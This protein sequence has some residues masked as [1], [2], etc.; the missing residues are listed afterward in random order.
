ML[1]SVTS[2]S[3][4]CMCGDDAHFMG[5]ATALLALSDRD[6]LSC[7]MS[8]HTERCSCWGT[9]APSPSDMDCRL[10][11][12]ALLFYVCTLCQLVATC[13][14]GSG[15]LLTAC[16]ERWQLRVKPFCQRQRPTALLREMK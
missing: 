15:P 14:A 2:Q 6:H 9:S 11:L 4:R 10:G 1:Y 5:G 7:V 16:T 12:I 3:C 8:G 13:P